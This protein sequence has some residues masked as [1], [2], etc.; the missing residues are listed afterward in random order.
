[1]QDDG[2]TSRISQPQHTPHR[3]LR[4]ITGKKHLDHHLSPQ[5]SL[6]ITCISVRPYPAQPHGPRLPIPKNTGKDGGD[7]Q[8]KCPAYI[9]HITQHPTPLPPFRLIRAQTGGTRQHTPTS[10]HQP[11]ETQNNTCRPRPAQTHGA[12]RLS[13]AHSAGRIQSGT[14]PPDSVIPAPSRRTRP[15][16]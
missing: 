14:R 12:R 2:G 16:K 13:I 4:A 6:E 5:Q 9:T 10:L 1:M 8:R 11:S 7:R 3:T 15:T